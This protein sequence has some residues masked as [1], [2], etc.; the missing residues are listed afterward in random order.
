MEQ[1]HTNTKINND[2]SATATPTMIRDYLP[3]FFAVA[4]AVI[5]GLMLA[6]AYPL[7]RT[8]SSSKAQTLAAQSAAAPTATYEASG[9]PILHSDLVQYGQIPK[10][11]PFTSTTIP[12]ALLKQH[13]TKAGT[14][15]VIRVLKGQLQYII[16]EPRISVHVVD[17]SRPGIIE[18][19]KYHQVKA[20]T[21]D[22]EFHV[23]FYRLPGTRPAVEKR[24]GYSEE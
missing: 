15:G 11:K 8:F 23:E 17:A 13:N 4:A 24:E 16:H 14:W 1:T 21:D 18:P 22:L 2:M 10:K 6:R 12:K 7:R 5:G 19:N 9:M 3:I 20:L